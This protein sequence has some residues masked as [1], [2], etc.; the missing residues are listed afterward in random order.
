[1]VIIKL[2]ISGF[3]WMLWLFLEIVKRNRAGSKVQRTRHHSF[4]IYA[5]REI[6]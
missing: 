4:Y 5:D 6:I 2:N 3:I 1:M